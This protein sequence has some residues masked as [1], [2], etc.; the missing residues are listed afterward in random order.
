MLSRGLLSRVHF[1]WTITLGNLL[2]IAVIALMFG[3]GVFRL[4]ANHISHF[5]TRINLRF[6]AVNQRFNA[7]EADVRQMRDWIMPKG[8]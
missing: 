3:G 8:H 5:E 7:L 2:S 4:L 1:D 6:D